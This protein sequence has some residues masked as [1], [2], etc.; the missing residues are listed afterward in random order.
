M[1]AEM[2]RLAEERILKMVGPELATPE[3]IKAFLD[4]LEK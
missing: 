2:T 4:G 1:H 3:G